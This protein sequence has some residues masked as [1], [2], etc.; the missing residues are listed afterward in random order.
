MTLPVAPSW[1]RRESLAD[2]VTWLTEPHV[3]PF[4]RCNIWHVRGRDRDLL[5]DTGLGLVSLRQ[6]AVD[7]FE[8]PVTCVLTHA[9]FDHVGGAE[10][11]PDRRIHPAERDE[12]ASGEGF[13]GLTA[14][15]L[16]DDL[17]R[18]LTLAGYAV[19][20]VLLD[21]VPREG[22]RPQGYRPPPVHPTALLRDN[23][24][25]DLGDRTFEV[26]HVP[27]HSPG[28]VALW[29]ARTGILF[30]GDALYD[31]P[32]LYDLAGSNIDDYAR[33]LERLQSLPVAIVHAGH[34]PSFGRARFR[35][36]IAR[37]LALWRRLG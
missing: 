15:D 19:P 35:D 14:E 31:G 5:V 27:G 21:A 4:A 18:Q 25:L 28:S 32:L 24:V 10:E 13:A 26:L 2:G 12:L 33:T 3:D 22:F 16:G 34:D 7:L 37:Y 17:V 20:R 23:D 30:S 6:A 1:Y 8:H 11:Q 36:I 9:H 29:E